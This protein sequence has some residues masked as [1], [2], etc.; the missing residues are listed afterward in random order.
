[1]KLFGSVSRQSK[2]DRLEEQQR[3]F[4]RSLAQEAGKS[5]KRLLASLEREK[6]V[7]S[8]IMESHNAR[9]RSLIEEE[10]ELNKE[11]LSL[12]EEVKKGMSEV[13][14]KQ[15]QLD[16]QEKNLD[17]KEKKLNALQR[18]YEKKLD[19]LDSA[20]KVVAELEDQMA[21][22]VHE[23]GILQDSIRSSEALTKAI[24]AKVTKKFSDLVEKEMEYKKK[25]ERLTEFV[26]VSLAKAK[27]KEDAMEALKKSL[28]IKESK[29]KKLEE[30]LKMHAKRQKTV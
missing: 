16:T 24:E 25:E 19:E 2:Q 9:M 29:L 6:A 4:A 22:N 10:T 18:V 30:R 14:A 17:I 26:N 5:E 13:Y 7:S 28:E 23:T 21:R 15:K 20:R 12:R 3:N 27:A 1:M 11:V 8:E